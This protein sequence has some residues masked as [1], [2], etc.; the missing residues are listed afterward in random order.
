LYTKN[1]LDK[2]LNTLDTTEWR[3]KSQHGV[4]QKSAEI[5]S[6]ELK[7]YSVSVRVNGCTLRE[8]S[9]EGDIWIEGRKGSKYRIRVAN[10][11]AKRILAVVSV[12]G[13]SIMTGKAAS[14]NAGGYIINPFGH[15]DIPGWRLDDSKIAEFEFSK[16]VKSYAAKTDRPANIGIIGCAVVEEYKSEVK[17]RIEISNADM[18]I[19]TESGST[20]RTISSTKDPFATTL[21]RFAYSA[22][23]N[24]ANVPSLG[25]EFGNKASHA[26]R[27]VPFTRSDDPPTVLKI[28]YAD[29]DELKRRGIDID[30]RPT[31]G[32]EPFPAD[33]GCTP[34][35]GWSDRASKS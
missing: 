4:G 23:P 3:Q 18:P 30:P 2:S 17:H 25:T 13:L 14:K 10:N 32:P 6:M 19:I 7:Q 31:I 9:H 5:N 16:S 26:V 21:D 24:I 12:D 1:L 8:F 27:H 15:I 34:P 35:A 28:R 11:S 22:T 33:I 20:S 29:R